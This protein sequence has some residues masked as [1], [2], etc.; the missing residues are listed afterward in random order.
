MSHEGDLPGKNPYI[1]QIVT[2]MGI[3]RD[4][5]IGHDKA[6]VEQYGAT[7]EVWLSAKQFLL[8]MDWGEQNRETIERLAREAEA[9]E[10]D[11]GR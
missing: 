11:H 6:F 4:V 7:D 1:V 10:D 5:R 9:K 8:L 3:V 2:L